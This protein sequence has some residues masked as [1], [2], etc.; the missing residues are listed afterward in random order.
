MNDQGK[1]EESGL[2]PEMSALL[3]DAVRLLVGDAEDPEGL[4]LL[5]A[6]AKA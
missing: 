1:N 6:Y 3:D 4:E 5:A 2:S